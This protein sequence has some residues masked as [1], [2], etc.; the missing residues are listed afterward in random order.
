[1]HVCLCVI[2]LSTPQSNGLN[3]P[4]YYVYSSRNE[5]CKDIWWLLLDNYHTKWGETY[6]YKLWL[7]LLG[8]SIL[9]FITYAIKLYHGGNATLNLTCATILL[10]IVVGMSLI[11]CW[12]E[13]KTIDVV[14]GLDT[15]LPQNCFVI[16]DCSEMEIFSEELVVGD[17]LS[18]KCGQRIHA[19]IRILHS[20]GDPD[21]VDYTMEEVASHISVFDAKNIAFGGSYCTEGDG[22]GLVIRTAQFMMLGHFAEIESDARKTS[23]QGLLQIELS[24]FVNW[25]CIVA[26]T[27]AVIFFLIGCVVTKFQNIFYHFITGFLII[28]VANVP[29]GLPPTVMSQLAIIARRMAKKNA[30]IKKPDV[31]DE[32]GAATVIATDKAGTLTKNLMVLT[33]LWYNKQHHSALEEIKRR[34]MKPLPHKLGHLGVS[35]PNHS[36][37]ASPSNSSPKSSIVSTEPKP[38]STEFESP[39]LEMINVMAVCNRAQFEKQK[40]RMPSQ[41]DASVASQLVREGRHFA[42]YSRHPSEVRQY[43]GLT[44]DAQ[45]DG[46]KHKKFTVVYETGHQSVREG[47]PN[48]SSENM[49]KVASTAY[50]GYG[51]EIDAADVE[52]G[53]DGRLSRHQSEQVLNHQPHRKNKKRD[54]R[55]VIGSPSDVALLR[56]V[57]NIACVDGVRNRYLNLFEIP[58]NS[59]RCWQLVIAR[60]MAEA[61]SP[62]AVELLNNTGEQKEDVYE[63][64][65]TMNV[66]MMKGAPETILAR[67]NKVLIRGQLVDIGNEFKEDCQKVWDYYG[68]KGSRVIGFS[69]RHFLAKK[70]TKFTSTSK[71]YP[72]ENLVFLGM[73]ALLDPPRA[74][75]RSAI[76]QCKDAGIK[77]YM[78]T[79]DHPTAAYAI[80]AR[81]GLIEI[82]Y[83]QGMIKSKAPA[84]SSKSTSALAK[85]FTSHSAVSLD[86]DWNKKADWAMVAG[87]ALF[88]YDKT[89]WDHLLAHPYIVFARTTP[90]QKRLIVEECQKRGEIVAVTGGGVNDA[91]AL[92]KANIGIALGAQGSDVA[93]KAANIVLAD[94]NFATI[95]TGIEEGR[96]LFDNL[97]LSLA[98]TLAH[99]WPEVCPIILNFVLGMPLGL[100]PLQI[101][102]I[103]LACELPP[104]VSLAYEHPERDIMNVPPRGKDTALVSNQLLIYSY[105]FS[106][107]FITIGCYSAYISVYWYHG[108]S[109]TDLFFTADRYFQHNSGNFTTQA[110]IVFEK[111]AQMEIRG[112]AAAAWQITLVMSQ[113]VHLFMCMTR[114]VSFFQHGITNLAPLIAVVIQIL[115]LN[116]FVY[117]P[118]MQYFMRISSPPS[119]VWVKQF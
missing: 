73:C 20:N 8:A 50:M 17:L 64:E 116:L 22:I 79:G 76:R 72:A 39:L 86:I 77:V 2:D 74:G 99:L 96:L 80:A 87:E 36:R 98:Y 107:T 109:T 42:E 6:F 106:G 48:S 5:N 12:Q 34:H 18:I 60:C 49:R 105:L 85:M 97:R 16:R 19:D 75:A 26:I 57:N 68:S 56:Y 11:S 45:S 89:Q 88:A 4:F 95:V 14:S 108:I 83:R 40:K 44:M 117:T 3:E 58:F 101:L 31:I 13:R 41:R 47:T 35:D 51:D 25:I 23:Q 7:L 115:L 59:V 28:I 10:G 69:Q 82:D 24:K 63:E 111:E 102:S 27:M 15:I 62:D 118:S 1:M 30:Y 94:D 71:N 53:I 65:Y 90:E 112:Q 114:R 91:P 119:H 54:N 93:R 32:L 104:A 9:S 38:K 70:S 66:V 29:Q 46:V 92:A 37:S 78:I 67:C 81:I 84:N 100:D 52:A 110:G 113:V 55:R 103:D 21:P 33:D 43:S 61:R